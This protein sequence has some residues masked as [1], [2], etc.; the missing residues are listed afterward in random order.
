MARKKSQFSM[1]DVLFGA[2]GAL[3][4]LAANGVINKALAN[5]PEGNRQ[6]IGKALPIAKAVGGA[7]MAIK[8]G[9]DRK[10]RFFSAGIATAG[11]IETG[12]KFQPNLFSISGTGDLFSMIGNAEPVRLPVA[13]DPTM[14]I[15]E[16][17][18]LG[19]RGKK[20]AML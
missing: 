15:E 13:A 6:M 14:D 8:K 4:G 2:G 7:Y 9:V 16:G 20:L 18:V 17:A 5:M 1:E 11:A 10:W 19:V 12:V 3:V